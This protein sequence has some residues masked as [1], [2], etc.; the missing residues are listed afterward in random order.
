MVQPSETTY[1]LPPIP[2][3]LPLRPVKPEE[4]VRIDD[5]PVKGQP[6]QE[7]GSERLSES[8]EYLQSESAEIPLR[9]AKT[10]P[11]KSSPDNEVHVVPDIII[12][13]SSKK[14]PNVLKFVLLL[15][16]S[17]ALLWLARPSYYEASLTFRLDRLPQSASAT[18]P[19]L[20]QFFMDPGVAQQII[21]NNVALPASLDKQKTELRDL[22]K[23]FH[24]RLQIAANGKTITLSYRSA[25]PEYASRMLVDL[26]AAFREQFVRDLQID[27]VRAHSA[28]LQDRL[29]DLQAQQSAARELIRREHDL[30]YQFAVPQDLN[31]KLAHL[32]TEQVLKIQNEHAQLKAQLKTIDDYFT[33]NPAPGELLDRFAS[34]A[35]AAWKKRYIMLALGTYAGSDNSD[36][37]NQLNEFKSGTIEDVKRSS[38]TPFPVDLEEKFTLLSQKYFI[39]A[40]L[41]ALDII[42]RKRYMESGEVQQAGQSLKTALKATVV[43]HKQ[44]ALI[45]I[46][47]EHFEKRIVKLRSGSLASRVSQRTYQPFFIEFKTVLFQFLVVVAALLIAIILYGRGPVRPGT[48]ILMPNK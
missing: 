14:P 13:K 44:R 17:A 23:Q 2:E 36:L 4:T 43:M 28:R 42:I 7:G 15:T 16:I 3:P 30:P 31:D 6:V 21:K 35:D 45:G 22:E 48:E 18:L 32:T 8:P 1:I 46:E 47:R 20:K 34:H 12:S 9:P 5:H 38:R 24:E 26:A 10:N 29:K 11:P 19:R 33:R 40:S 39:A 27:R 37:A 25:D 41:E